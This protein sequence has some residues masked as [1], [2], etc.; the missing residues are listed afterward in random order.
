MSSIPEFHF[1]FGAVQGQPFEEAAEALFRQMEEHYNEHIKPAPILFGGK[2][3]SRPVTVGFDPASPGG[4]RAVTTVARD[5]KIEQ[6]VEGDVSNMSNEYEIKP[7]EDV[8]L[9]DCFVLTGVTVE[10]LEVFDKLKTQGPPWPL[11]VEGE[12]GKYNLGTAK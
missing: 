11:I 1:D 4:D 12:S 5:G 3:V 2:S 8:G 7:G 9:K 10:G 6:V